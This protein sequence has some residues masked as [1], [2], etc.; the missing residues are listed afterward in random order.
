MID[1]NNYDQSLLSV[2]NKC[3]FKIMCHDESKILK[4][5]INTP[6]FNQR[7]MTTTVNFHAV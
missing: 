2:V 6:V 3:D 7:N 1:H 5:F 4:K